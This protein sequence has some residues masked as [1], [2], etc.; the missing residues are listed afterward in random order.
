[1][2]SD[3]RSS[4]A[5]G[6]STREV[7][8]ARAS[9]PQSRPERPNKRERR[10]AKRASRS[11]R[12][13]QLRLVEASA[14]AHER[15][16]EARPSEDS[17]VSRE[18]GSHERRGRRRRR[19]RRERSREQP[20]SSQS[21]TRSSRA[22]RRE[23]SSSAD[24]R[25]QL[26]L[27]LRTIDSVLVAIENTAWQVR[28][29]G[30]SAQSAEGAEV[31]PLFALRHELTQWPARLSRLTS[32][33]LVLGR[34][35]TAYRL[36]TTKAAFMSER[37]AAEAREALHADSAHRLYSLSVRQGGAFLKLGQ[38]LASRPDLLPEAY[39]RELGKLQDAAP[40][41]PFLEIA[42]A[43]ERELGK[44]VEA[45]FASFDEKPL[46]AASIGQVHRA[47]WRDGREV[48]V[49]VQ[50][51]NIEALVKLDMELLEVF[52]RALAQ[53]LPPLDYDTI[54]R[55]SRAMV[56]AE[57]DYRREAELTQ[58]MADFFAEHTSISVPSVVSELSTSR[59][60]V[61][62]FRPGV[63]LTNALDRMAEAREQGDASGQE[64]IT[65]TLS[66]VL[67]A[68]ARQ[69]LQAGLFQADPHPGN[70]LVD[71][72][73]HV[74]VLDFG[75]AKQLD[76][77]QRANLRALLKATLVR[78]TQA[79]G[80]AMLAMGFETRSG[81]RE[82]LVAYA[83]NALE[84]MALV[85]GKNGGFVSQMEMVSGLAEFG[86][87]VES[88]PIT[89]LPE[90][91]V[92]LGRVFGTLSGLFVHYQ[93]DVSATRAVLPVVFAALVEPRGASSEAGR[94]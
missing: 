13:A 16:T 48:A 87:F 80:D 23:R 29:L 3:Y 11:E 36:H 9:V 46:A 20:A 35:A 57:L 4:L 32:T 1:M 71:E 27:W 7:P 65:E 61:T 86:R 33:G 67:E 92:M 60:L 89:K 21:P 38:M 47:T 75:C 51:P 78:D 15:S 31:T 90:E 66:R 37:A 42:A 41:V 19:A 54:I 63:K 68:Y 91:F 17:L 93:P 82:G 58:T 44:P 22:D 43:L 74:T 56:S 55:E 34:V 53:N 12:R 18:D 94:G 73:G 52:V 88:D 45:L 79:M 62:S 6:T 10:A 76:L 14:S 28:E 72:M 83:K 84:Q 50:R 25:S 85:Q 39:V 70:L 40:A 59:I 24:L 64:R 49:K 69:V 2:K 5:R 8:E 30:A 26:K 81:T 77:T